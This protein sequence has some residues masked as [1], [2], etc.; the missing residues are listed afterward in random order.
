M[1]K[2]CSSGDDDDNNNDDDDDD[3]RNDL[4]LA[5]KRTKKQVKQEYVLQSFV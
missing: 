5:F 4:P 1:P 3:D 2:D